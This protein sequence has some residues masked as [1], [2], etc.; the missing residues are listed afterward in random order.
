MTVYDFELEEEITG[1]P[2][3]IKGTLFKP[4]NI[5]YMLMIILIVFG[6]GRLGVETIDKAFLYGS[7]GI[8][9]P[10]TL[11]L[12]WTLFYH[13]T[14]KVVWAGGHSTTT[15]RFETVGDYRIIRLDGLP[16]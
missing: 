5:W 8:V 9:L 11:G 3:G 1:S 2:T 10:F 12:I 6:R 13:K 16:S 14:A 15:G 4:I 7:L